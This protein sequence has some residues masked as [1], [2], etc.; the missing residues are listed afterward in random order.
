MPSFRPNTTLVPPRASKAPWVYDW[1]LYAWGYD[2]WCGLTKSRA[3]ACAL[4]M[5]GARPGES[6]LEMALGTGLLFAKLA[7]IQGLVRCAGLDLSK[8]M[9][10]RARRRLSRQQSLRHSLCR[11]D[12]RSLPFASGAFDLIVNGYFMDLLSPGDITLALKEFRRVLKPTGRL[13][14]LVMAN[15]GPVLQ[16]IWMWLYSHR[17]GLVGGCR[18]V[19]LS[20]YLVQGDWQIELCQVISQ[21]GF[22]SEL[23]LA[24]PVC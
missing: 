7:G 13:V 15:Q 19:N 3:H 18:P 5:A 17:P 22:R 11:G 21:L 16:A 9:L 14:L 1:L 2:L 8:A 6:V 24:R 20:E 4:D 10:S 23:I 12:A